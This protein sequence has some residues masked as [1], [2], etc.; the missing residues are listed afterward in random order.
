[1]VV[2]EVQRLSRG[3]KEL[4]LGGEMEMP[5]ARREVCVACHAEMLTSRLHV[6]CA[7][8]KQQ[9][10]VFGKSIRFEQA[11]LPFVAADAEIA[12][13]W[14]AN[15]RATDRGYAVELWMYGRESS[16]A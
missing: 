12:A 6:V 5:V 14:K 7:M 10:A 4:G 9:S 1:M 13:D 8:S 3:I 2:A 15:G 11:G 16:A